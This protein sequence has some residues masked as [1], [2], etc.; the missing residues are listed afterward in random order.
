M[1]ISP[2]SSSTWRQ[3]KNGWI[4][5]NYRE[6]RWKPGVLSL[7][8]ER[9]LPSPQQLIIEVESS[10]KCW[11]KSIKW[12]RWNICFWNLPVLLLSSQKYCSRFD[13]FSLWFWRFIVS[14]Y[15]F[16]VQVRTLL[17]FHTVLQAA[18]E[19]LTSL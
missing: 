10:L 13:L 15:Y 7:K 9:G 16:F 18:R 3:K 2:F 12:S 6:L 14:C 8:K 17:L 1:K 5:Q 19:D 4:F 11:R